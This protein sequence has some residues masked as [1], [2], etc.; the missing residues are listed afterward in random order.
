M[1]NF[2]ILFL[3]QNLWTRFLS[4]LPFIICRYFSHNNSSICQISLISLS[5]RLQLWTAR[6][7]AAIAHETKRDSGTQ[8]VESNITCTRQHTSRMIVKSKVRECSEWIFAATA[9]GGCRTYWL[10]VAPPR[11]VLCCAALWCCVSFTAA[12]RCVELRWV[13]CWWRGERRCTWSSSWSSS[14][15]QYSIFD[16]PIWVV[17][18]LIEFRCI[19]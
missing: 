11:A 6:C 7:H 16:L 10:A 2:T 12:E 5:F 13:H 4:H 18:F 1:L 15:C 19:I 17:F 9:V 14:R 3:C 8:R